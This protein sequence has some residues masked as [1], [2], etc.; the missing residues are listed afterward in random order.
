MRSDAFH[1][2][3]CY[4]LRLKADRCSAGAGPIFLPNF[5]IE[6]T[7]IKGAVPSARAS[8]LRPQ[9]VRRNTPSPGINTSFVCNDG[10]SW[11]LRLPREVRRKRY[12][13][14]ES[15][16]I[17]SGARLQLKVDRGKLMPPRAGHAS[18]SKTILP[19]CRLVRSSDCATGRDICVSFI[20]ALREQSL[21]ALAAW[22]MPA[23]TVGSTLGAPFP[24]TA[25]L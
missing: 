6:Q 2:L 13:R 3:R 10:G 8:R 23:P 17:A 24:G 11:Q 19:V 12:R 1:A 20:T 22:C 18:S 21:P 9:S 25:R 4:G 7:K 15:T 14:Q 16:L 5:V